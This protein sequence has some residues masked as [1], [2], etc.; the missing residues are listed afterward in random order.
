MLVYGKEAVLPTNITIPSFALMQFVDENPSSS[1][2]LRQDQILKMEEQ[3]EKAKAIHTH[4]QQIVKASFDTTFPSP[5]SF[6]L[7]DVVSNEPLTIC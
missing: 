3:R 2:Q 4:H 5:K 6:E 1:L 7:V